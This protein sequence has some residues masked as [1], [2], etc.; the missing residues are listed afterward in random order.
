M[1]EQN[2]LHDLVQ[3][4]LDQDYNK[5]NKI[6]GDMMGTKINDVLDQEKIRLAD[7]IY[8]GVEADDE[9]DDDI[10]GDEDGDDQLE[11][12]LDAEDESEPEGEDE[13]EESESE[14]DEEEEIDDEDD[15]VEN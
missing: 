9:D 3:H 12:D 8:N 7:Q 14:G 6:F 1:E 13:E 15:A 5:A 11:L 10:M 2:P 4:A